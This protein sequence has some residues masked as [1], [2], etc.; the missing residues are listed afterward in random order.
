MYLATDLGKKSRKE[1]GPRRAVTTLNKESKKMWLESTCCT[2]KNIPH[3]CTSKC[4]RGT[5]SIVGIGAL[6]HK[7][8]V[9]KR[10]FPGCYFCF[11]CFLK[12]FGPGS[13]R[14]TG[15]SF[16]NLLEASAFFRNTP[17]RS[18]LFSSLVWWLVNFSQIKKNSSLLGQ[19]WS[20]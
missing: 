5:L 18:V 17:P 9:D 4:R 3:D 8:Y 1:I 12:F 2:K 11:F 15:L 6:D 20:V 13:A 14:G 16:I 19:A 7:N 10:W